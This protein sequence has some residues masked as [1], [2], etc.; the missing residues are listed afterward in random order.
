MPLARTDGSLLHDMD[1]TICWNALGG[2]GSGFGWDRRD[3]RPIKNLPRLPGPA[4]QEF[5]VSSFVTVS[6]DQGGQPTGRIFLLNGRKPFQ[7][8]D[9]AWLESI[10]AHVSPALENIFLLRHL[11]ARAIEAERS[12]IARDV[13][14]G[15]LHT[16]LRIDL[17]LEVLLRRLPAAPA[18][19]V[20]GLA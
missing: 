1:A 10:A 8:Q 20:T 7:K 9:L 2:P 15:I 17:Q 18:Q 4:R 14:D 6:F 3:G 16:V 13:H 11:R 12:R 19:P 5:K